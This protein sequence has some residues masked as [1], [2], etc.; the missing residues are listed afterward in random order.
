MN[1]AAAPIPHP[2]K[3]PKKKLNP[4][5][6]AESK[7]RTDDTRKNAGELI[8]MAQKTYAI[9]RVEASVPEFRPRSPFIG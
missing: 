1:P 6:L 4:L 2:T 7:S 5:R 9:M 8:E 3:Y